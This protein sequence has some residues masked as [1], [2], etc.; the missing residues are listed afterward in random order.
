MNLTTTLRVM[1]FYAVSC[2]VTETEG[3]GSNVSGAGSLYP[4]EL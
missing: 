4:S 2:S 3:I 1:I